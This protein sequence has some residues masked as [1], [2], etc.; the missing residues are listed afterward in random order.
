MKKL[1]NTEIE[2]KKIVAYRKKA[3]SCWYLKNV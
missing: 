2:L 3:Y 1:G